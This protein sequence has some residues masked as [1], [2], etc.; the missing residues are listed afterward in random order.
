MSDRREAILRAALEAV[1]GPR[2]DAYG[3]P[4]ANFRRIADLWNAY[5]SER[6]DRPITEQD[7]AV[8]SLLIKVARIMETP[9]M[10]DHWLDIAGYAAC[11]WAVTPDHA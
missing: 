6:L 8:L 5:L 11:G 1:T 3:H 7:V 10:Q 4:T 9:S 2:A